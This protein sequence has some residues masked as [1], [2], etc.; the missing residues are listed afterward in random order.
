VSQCEST[1]RHDVRVRVPVRVSLELRA[2]RPELTTDTHT[3][4]RC[5]YVAHAA[6]RRGGEQGG[7]GGAHRERGARGGHVRRAP[8]P[9]AD[10]AGEHRARRAAG[11]GRGG[12][13]G[14]RGLRARVGRVPVVGP[15]PGVDRRGGGRRGPVLP[16]AAHAG[17][18]PVRRRRGRGGGVAAVQPQRARVEPRRVQAA[19]APGGGAGGGAQG[20]ARRRRGGARGAAEPVRAHDGPVPLRRGGGAGGG[21]V[22]VQGRRAAPGGEAPLA[23][24]IV[25]PRYAALGIR[26]SRYDTYVSV[27][28]YSSIVQSLDATKNLHCMQFNSRQAGISSCTN[29]C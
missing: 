7:G 20:P 4:A 2:G 14:A 21:L 10:G 26:R 3:H 12:R 28:T 18:G 6:G 23:R 8:G 11:A 27:Y 15:V 29:T 16:G 19:G 17:L 5:R 1:G 9:A 13:R 24:G 25:Q 22:H